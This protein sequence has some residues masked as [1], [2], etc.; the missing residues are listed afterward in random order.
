MNEE[1]MNFQRKCFEVEYSLGYTVSGQKML[2][3]LAFT[4]AYG[5]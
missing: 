1:M 3:R 5:I 4:V 2:F